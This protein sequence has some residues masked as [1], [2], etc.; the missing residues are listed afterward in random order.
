MRLPLDKIIHFL[1]GWAVA[2][3]LYPLFNL[4]S[5]FI[6]ALLGYYKERRD[7]K[8]GLG[9]YDPED[10][11]ATIYGGCGATAVGFVVEYIRNLL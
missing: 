2:A 4:F 10:M 5:V 3:S 9:T 1:A 11:W 6:A 7:K 8:T